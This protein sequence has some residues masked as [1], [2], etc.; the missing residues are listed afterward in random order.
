M[1]KAEELKIR[2]GI[3]ELVKQ[4]HRNAVSKKWWSPAPTF[5]EG[6]MLIVSELSEALEDYRKGYVVSEQMKTPSCGTVENEKPVGIPSE[7]ADVLI[8]L[9]DLCGGFKVPLSDA[10]IKKMN[11]NRTRTARHGGKKL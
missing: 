9:C 7:L 2:R 10:V 5:A 11:Y 3:D 1:T 4:C 8:R 6:L